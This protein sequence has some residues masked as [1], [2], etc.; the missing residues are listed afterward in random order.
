MILTKFHLQSWIIDPKPWLAEN[1]WLYNTKQLILKGFH[2]VGFD[3]M[4]HSKDRE[5]FGEVLSTI[6]MWGSTPGKIHFIVNNFDKLTLLTLPSSSPWSLLSWSSPPS[7]SVYLR[8]MWL[9]SSSCC[10]SEGGASWDCFDF[11]MLNSSA[12]VM[13][14]IIS[15]M[16]TT[17]MTNDDD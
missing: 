13:V 6:Q 3:V 11:D 10:K 4:L 12:L 1:K 2:V 17:M 9:I 14:L 15:K 8:T 7:S 5:A 16:M